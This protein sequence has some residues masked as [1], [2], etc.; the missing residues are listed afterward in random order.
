MLDNKS[1]K[2]IKRIRRAK[3]LLYKNKIHRFLP[4]GK[5]NMA[6]HISGLSEW[7]SKHRD[8]QYSTFPTKTFDHSQRVKL[9]ELVIQNEIGDKDIDYLEFGVATGGS[10]RWWMEH[11]KNENSRFYGF[12]TFTGLPEDWG[13]FKKGDMSNGN[14]PPQIDDTRHAFYQGIFQHTLIEFL[15]TYDSDKMKVIHMDADLYSSTLFVLTTLTPYLNKGDILFFDEFNVPMHEYKA[16][17]EWANS[18]YIDY[19]VLGE[20]NNY[21]QVVMRIEKGLK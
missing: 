19:T 11:I 5:L 2:K 18:F 10:F 3:Y 12:D 17:T 21:Y 20:V 8:L 16:F 1:K 9:F 15:K 6:G 14:E 13:P 7:I 4:S